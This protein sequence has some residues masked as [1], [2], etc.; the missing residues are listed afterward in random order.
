METQ[1]Y[2]V[3]SHHQSPYVSSDL[4]KTYRGINKKAMAEVLNTTDEIEI[5]LPPFKN[6]TEW[7]REN[8]KLYREGCPWLGG[9]RITR[10]IPLELAEELNLWIVQ[11]TL[12]FSCSNYFVLLPFSQWAKMGNP[13]AKGFYFGNP[14]K[15]AI[16]CLL[17]LSMPHY[18]TRIYNYR[19]GLRLLQVLKE[20]RDLFKAI[21]DIPS[22]KK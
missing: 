20:R 18:A 13:F 14:F 6:H 9:K 10:P 11:P 4:P 8:W 2:W 19:N 17:H 3:L 16:V 7:V 5:L 15:Q 21:Q 12:G 1:I 22:L